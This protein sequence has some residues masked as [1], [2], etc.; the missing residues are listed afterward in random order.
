MN[1]IPR[2]YIVT[3]IVCGL[4]AVLLFG[5]STNNEPTVASTVL[6]GIFS[7]LTPTVLA[8]GLL[9]SMPANLPVTRR[10]VNNGVSPEVLVEGAIYYLEGFRPVEFVHKSHLDE[11]IFK[12]I[13]EDSE[14]NSRLKL[15]NLTSKEVELYISLDKEI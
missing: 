3:S 1:N 8:I 13:A 6:F 11:Y 10:P 7:I 2:S 14:K 4:I 15:T 5:L 9:S 12:V